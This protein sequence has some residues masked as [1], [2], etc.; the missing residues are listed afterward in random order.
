MKYIDYQEHRQHGTFNFPIAYYHENPRSPRYHMTYHWHTNYEI[1]YI[2]E[3][4]FNLTLDDTTH[5]FNGGD[6]VFVSDGMLHGGTPSDCFYDC[7][8]F[9]L[10]ML[11]KNNNA[12][13]KM[14]Q[15]IIQHKILINTHLSEKDSTIVDIVHS[16][17][18]EL[19]GKKSGYEFQVQGLLYLLFGEIINK[20]LYTVNSID[21]ITSE[22]LSSIKEVLSF[23]SDNYAN[24]ISLDELA[25]IAGMNPKYFCRYFKSMTDRTPIDYLNYYRIECA[26]EL[27]S[28]K[29]MS[30]REVAISCGFND[31]SYFIKTFNK[32]KGITP[33]QYVKREF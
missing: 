20:E 6:V 33:K 23:I 11:L 30:I 26:C 28:T 5:I 12:C 25:H 18:Y 14:V 32:Y 7:V 4:H 24:N 16:L 17:C 1:I 27:L 29:D 3:G 31:E 10:Q 21:N 9:D 8:V 22:R 13:S 15:D 2:R 19:S